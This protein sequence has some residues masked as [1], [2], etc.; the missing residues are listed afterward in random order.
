MDM[1]EHQLSDEQITIYDNYSQSLCRDPSEYHQRT[2][3]L[4]YHTGEQSPILN[5]ELDSHSSAM[6]TFVGA[7][8]FPGSEA[9]AEN[10]AEPRQLALVELFR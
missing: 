7:I 9:V 10:P 8:I 2:G 6:S 5:H 3:N 1:L 4:Q